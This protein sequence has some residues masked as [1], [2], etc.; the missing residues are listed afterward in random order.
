M[1]EVLKQSIFLSLGLASLAR[2][3]AEELAADVSHRAKLSE[4]DASAFRDELMR[5]RDAAQRDL[6]AEIDRRIDHFFIQ[7]GI[8]KAGVRKVGEEGRVE[9]QTFLDQLTEDALTRVGI[10]RAEDVQSL[11]SRI[12]LLERKAASK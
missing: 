8:L 10:A 7:L 1:F 5:R 3:K 12:E 2:D 9:L 4:A 6:E 11:T